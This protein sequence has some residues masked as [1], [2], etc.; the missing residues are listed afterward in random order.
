MRLATTKPVSRNGTARITSGTTRAIRALVF[1]EPSTITPPSSSPSRFEPE[2]PM[3]TEAGWKLWTRKPSA[4]PA[5]QPAS[6]PAASSCRSK[7][8][9]AKPIAEI[10]Q[11]PAASP[12]TPSE[13]FTT[14]ITATRP[15]RVSGPPRS[16]RSTR[17]TNGNVKLS[18]RTP[19]STQIRPA[20]DLPEQLDAGR[21]VADVVERCPTA[22]ISAAAPRMP[23]ISELAGRNSAPATSTPA[24]IARPPS[25][26][27]CSGRARAPAPGRPRRCGPRGARRAA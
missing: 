12:S 10:A 23:R 14:F 7:A 24:R 17:P 3:K 22:V 2:S 1:S 15:S 11:T 6:T 18:T 8:M 9:T 16:P 5:M 19:E 13:K 21:E 4:A 20:A 26:G 25:S 27:V